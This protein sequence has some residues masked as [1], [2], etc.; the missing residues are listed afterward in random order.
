MLPGISCLLYSFDTAGKICWNV[1]MHR[2]AARQRSSN[3]AAILCGRISSCVDKVP[4]LQLITVCICSFSISAPDGTKTTSSER[5]DFHS[6]CT[7]VDNWTLDLFIIFLWF[8]L[9]TPLASLHYNTRVC[10]CWSVFLTEGTGIHRCKHTHTDA[11]KCIPWN[12]A[13]PC[14]LFALWEV[15]FSMAI[16]GASPDLHNVAVWAPNVWKPTCHPCHT[17]GAPSR[18]QRA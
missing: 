2:L 16:P 6:F 4:C 14:L 10:A 13:T 8:H 1:L 3:A 12:T 15:I 7:L 9:H 5:T 18:R 17:R 11:H